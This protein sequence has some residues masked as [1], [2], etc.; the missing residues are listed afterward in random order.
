MKLFTNSFFELLKAVDI[1]ASGKSGNRT[2]GRSSSYLPYSFCSAISCNKNSLCVGGTAFIGYNISVIVKC[3]Q[4]FKGFIFGYLSNSNKHSVKC[5]AALLAVFV[6]FYFNGAKLA[7][8]CFKL[9]NNS[10]KYHIDVILFFKNSEKPFFAR[11][12]WKILNNGNVF[13][14]VAKHNR[15]LKCGISASN[16]GNAFICEK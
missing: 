9:G 13:T 5:K 14:N 2:V 6:V 4:A 15:L 3:G 12:I 7:V 8:A 16:N 11:H 1:S 10:V